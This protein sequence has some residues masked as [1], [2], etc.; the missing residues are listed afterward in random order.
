MKKII[1]TI[2]LSLMY[3][4]SFSQKIIMSTERVESSDLQELLSFESIDYYKVLF[5]GKSLLGK[6]YLL[7]SKEIWNGV[8]TKIDTIVDS[9]K[10]K[11]IPKI[12]KETFG[13]KVIS[14]KTNDNFLKVKFRF[15]RFGTTKKYRAINSDDY[16][17]RDYGTNLN[18]SPGKNFYALA[19]ILPYEKDG[20]KMWCAVESNGVDVENWGKEY[21]IEH[22]VVFEMKFSE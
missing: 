14:K 16:S 13:F 7:V 6:D 20:W 21:G 8:I 10:N 2:V 15:S 3:S 17:L 22:Y 18:I 4:L 11:R 12:N 9:S 5:T 19:Y 1:L